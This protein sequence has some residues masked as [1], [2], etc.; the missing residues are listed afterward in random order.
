M[1]VVIAHYRTR[2]EHVATVREVLTRHA[3]ASEAE[4]GCVHFKAHQGKD[5]PATFALYEAYTDEAAFAAHRESAHFRANIDAVVAP[6][7]VE[8]TWATYEA[9]L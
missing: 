2:P 6:L 5:D 1:I 8:R 7:L 3:T 9:A 4:P